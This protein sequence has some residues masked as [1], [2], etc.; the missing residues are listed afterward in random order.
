MLASCL[1]VIVFSK[2]ST[3]LDWA[4]RAL[5]LGFVLALFPACQRTVD[6]SAHDPKWIA[7]TIPYSGVRDVNRQFPDYSSIDARILDQPKASGDASKAGK[8][9]PV[10]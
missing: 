2:P 8:K 7:T 6:M 3:S 5:M 9:G 4:A 1:P 10:R